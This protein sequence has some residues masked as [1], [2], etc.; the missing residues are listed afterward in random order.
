MDSK[1]ESFLS[2]VIYKCFIV[3]RRKKIELSRA[4]IISTT[5]HETVLRKLINNLTINRRKQSGESSLLKHWH[6]MALKP[7][8]LLKFIFSKQQNREMWV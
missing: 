2:F 3:R 6:Q 5:S 8:K 1:F 4:A 7:P